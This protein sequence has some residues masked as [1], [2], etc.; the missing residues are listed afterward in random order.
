MKKRKIAVLGSTGS[1]GT[2]TLDVIRA[3]P[4]DFKVYGLAARHNSSLLLE[5]VREKMHLDDFNQTLN[6]CI[7]EQARIL[8]IES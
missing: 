7:L 2:Q 4:E 3:F 1:I 5:Q 8:E 6:F